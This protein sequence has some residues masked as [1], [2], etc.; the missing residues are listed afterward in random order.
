MKKVLFIEW[1]KLGDGVLFYLKNWEKFVGYRLYSYICNCNNNKIL[2]HLR[3]DLDEAV[4]EYRLI[5]LYDHRM[6]DGLFS[7]SHEQN[8]ARFDYAMTRKQRRSQFIR[9]L[10][11]CF[12]GCFARNLLWKSFLRCCLRQEII[13]NSGR[14]QIKSLTRNSNL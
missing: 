14:Q 4:C 13:C 9:I 2:I 3:L 8:N 1:K 11:G 5:F 10:Y 12:G 6:L 7:L